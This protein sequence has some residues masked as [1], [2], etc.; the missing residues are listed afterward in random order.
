MSSRD[1]I[2]TMPNNN[3]RYLETEDREPSERSS[4]RAGNR[5]RKALFQY[6][7]DNVK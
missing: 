2:V 7:L 6:W 4:A 5:I 1:Y 3:D